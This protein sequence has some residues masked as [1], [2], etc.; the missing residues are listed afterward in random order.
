VDEAVAAAVVD[1][2]D[3]VVVLVARVVDVAADLDFV[4]L[5]VTALALVVAAGVLAAVI[6]TR[7]LEI[8]VAV[9]MTS[10]TVSM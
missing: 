1:V 7:V 4:V 2:T 3:G 10:W 8:T 9:A 6:W 5:E